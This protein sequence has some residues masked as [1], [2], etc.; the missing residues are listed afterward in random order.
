MT[1]EEFKQWREQMNLNRIEAAAALGM[2]RN[3]PQRY[4]E[5]QHIPRY[6]A[7]ACAA[8]LAELPPYPE[9]KTPLFSGANK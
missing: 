9:Q 2:G 5:G 7:L 6:I 4:E 3:Q 8:L 1:S